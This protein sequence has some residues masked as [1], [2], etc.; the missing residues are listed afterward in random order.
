MV[1]FTLCFAMVVMPPTWG[2]PFKE[3]PRQVRIFIFFPKSP[4]MRWAHRAGLPPIWREI[5]FSLKKMG[6]KRKF[7]NLIFFKQKFVSR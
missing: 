7:D 3:P 1:T 6:R 2:L 4:P 5:T